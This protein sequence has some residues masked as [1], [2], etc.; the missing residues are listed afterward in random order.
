MYGWE[1]RA[2]AG[3]KANIR[4]VEDKECRCLTTL[5]SHGDHGVMA[6]QAGYEGQ[7][8]GPQVFYHCRHERPCQGLFK[9]SAGRCVLCFVAM[10]YDD[11]GNP[12]FSEAVEREKKYN[13]M[14]DD[15]LPKSNNGNIVTFYN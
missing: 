10:R 14:E 5:L 8:A 12:L 13:E 6:D 15:L 11:I 2:S 4:C 3:A 1:K 9:G 7:C